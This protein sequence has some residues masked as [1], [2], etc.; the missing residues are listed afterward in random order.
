MEM[1]K[2]VEYLTCKERLRE[3][4]IKCGEQKVIGGSH[5]CI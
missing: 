4:G 1:I 5:Q 3:L 2:G